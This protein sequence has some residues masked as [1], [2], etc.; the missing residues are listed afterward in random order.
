M[1]STALLSQ[2]LDQQNQWQSTERLYRL[3][4]KL[5]NDALLVERVDG[6]EQIIGAPL[7]KGDVLLPNPQHFPVGSPVEAQSAKPNQ[8][9]GH[10]PLPS[11]LRDDPAASDGSSLLCGYRFEITVLSATSG[12]DLHSLLG[13]PV[14]LEVQTSSSR[15]SLRPIHGHISEAQALGSNGGLARYRLIV[16]PWLSFLRQRRDS[17]VFQ[18]KTVAEILDSLFSDYQ[19]QGALAPAW[20][21]ALADKYPKRSLLTQYRETDWHFVHRL[22][23]DEGLVCWFEHEGDTSSASLG[24]HTLVISDRLGLDAACVDNT[25][26]PLRFHRAS[27]VEGGDGLAAMAGALGAGPGGRD[28][29]Q[30]WQEHRQM[31]PSKVRLLSY[32]DRTLSNQA[33][34]ASIPVQYHGH[35]LELDDHI[36]HYGWAGVDDGERR[37]FNLLAAYQVQ[38]R[39][40][41]AGGTVRSL[42]PGQVF[43]LSQHHRYPKESRFRVLSVHHQG[44]N[45]LSA[46][47]KATLNREFSLNQEAEDFPEHYRNHAVCLYARAAVGMGESVDTPFAPAPVTGSYHSR[48]TVQGIQTATVVGLGGLPIDTDRN[49]RVKVQF[50]WQRGGSAHNRQTHSTGDDNAPA[51]ERAWAWVRVGAPAAGGNWGSS[52]IPRIGQEVLVNFL[53]GD[54]DRPIVVGAAYNGT[55]NTDAQHNEQAGSDGR[56][57]ANAPIWFA[58]DT[59]EHA[60]PDSISGIKTQAISHSQTGQSDKQAG[61]F[62]QIVFDDHP[63]HPRAELGTTQAYTW[64]QL[65]QTRHQQDNARREARSHGASLETRAHA[66]VRAGHGL[67]ISAQARPNANGGQLDSQEAEQ[68]LTQ[69]RER[70]NAIL[71]RA[72]KH[73][74]KLPDEQAAGKQPV[75]ENLKALQSSLAGFNQGAPAWTRPELIQSAPKGIGW[76][77]A[78]Q[79]SIN[80]SE[81]LALIGRD[82]QIGAQDT[83]GINASEGLRVFAGGTKPDGKQPE[84]TRG[85]RLLAASGQTIVQAQKAKA[86]LN[87]KQ[88]I[89]V[90]TNADALIASPTVLK[91]TAQGAGLELQGGNITLYVPNGLKMQ[92]SQKIWEGPAG[93]SHQAEKMPTSQIKGCALRLSAAA[94]AGGPF[95]AG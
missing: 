12:L 92:A 14:L 59:A 78:G 57:T 62:N 49:H 71:E 74:A 28:T 83:L 10:L 84:Q 55:G 80:A 6:V 3:H 73:S 13:A 24:K 15:T 93:A 63:D 90:S 29:F 76:L 61:G 22:I 89:T 47:F 45:N 69:Q 50:H 86:D 88:A 30:E 36:S 54:I 34:E 11:S 72:D 67:L 31:V 38:G 39:R 53:D 21:L 48:P 19:G 20:R 46:D 33:V 16:E 75:E 60:H 42:A 1:S 18:D 85:I 79:A 82:L 77:T 65:G 35:K 26:S 66:A 25:E 37:A 58:G 43:S 94:G 8:Q 95:T 41:F 5:G 52:F 27:A 56:I 17:W 70:L 44:R 87:A 51:N 91:L 2:F 81:H 32:D 23:E 68:T 4:T 64:L 40:I 7:P 9:L